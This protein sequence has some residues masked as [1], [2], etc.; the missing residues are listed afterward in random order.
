MLEKRG[1][2]MGEFLSS[3]EE[4]QAALAFEQGKAVAN[5]EYARRVNKQSPLYDQMGEEVVTEV[6]LSGI[7]RESSIAQ[8]IAKRQSMGSK[9]V[10]L[11]TDIDNTFYRRDMVEP[12]RKLNQV[13]QRNEW[14]LIYVTGRDLAMVRQSEELPQADIVVGAVGTEIYVQKEGSYVIDEE[15]RQLLQTNWSRD[16]VYQVA[17]KIVAEHPEIIFQSRDEP[18]A[19]ESGKV[20]EPPQEFKISLNVTGDRALAVKTSRLL[21]SEI[22]GAQVILSADIDD[23]QKHNIDLLPPNAGKGMALRYLTEKLGIRGVAAGDSGNDLTMLIEGGHPAIVVGGA[24]E[25]LRTAV[26][27]FEDTPSFNS[28]VKK[29]PNSQKILIGQDKIEEATQGLIHALQQGDFNPEDAL[30]L[31]PHFTSYRGRRDE[32]CLLFF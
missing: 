7:Y 11:F 30:G 4:K 29:L 8:K 1:E 19:F 23:P 18:G 17:Q 2:E 3:E 28:K 32:N 27:G 9:P 20:K 14:G 15:F 5:L 25:E 6:E 24:R 26:M 21:E 22:K 31:L 16:E 10:A 12:M 13:L